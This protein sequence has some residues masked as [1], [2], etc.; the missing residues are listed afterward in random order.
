MNDIRFAVRL[1]RKNSG[2]TIAAVAVLALGIGA[3]TAIFSLVNAVLLKPLPYREPERLTMLWGNVQRAVVERRGNSFPD[4]FDW[5]ERSRSFEAMSAVWDAVWI[6]PGAPDSERIQGEIVSASYFPLLGVN[7]RMGRL[8]RPEEDHKQDAAPPVVVIG[9]GLWKRRFGADPGILG[10]SIQVATGFRPADGY[11]R[12][13]TVVGVMPDGFRGLSDEAEMWMPVMAAGLGPVLE[14]RGTRGFPALAR[15]RPG[16]NREMAQRDLDAIST[17]LQKEYPGTNRQRGV[18]VALLS[19]EVTGELRPALLVILGAAGFVMLLACAN[20]GNLMLSRAEARHKELAVRAALGAGKVRLLRQLSIEAMVL[21]AMGA[22]AGLLIA[23][24]GTEALMTA[25]PVRFLSW[26]RPEIDLGVIGFTMLISLVTA[27]VL[28]L[29]PAL[30][31]SEPALQE[32]LQESSGRTSSR[33]RLRGFLVASE[34]A[35]ALVL[36]AGA[37]L[38]IRSFHALSRLDPG[39]RTDGVLT[40]RVSLPPRAQDHPGF[41]A[42][43]IREK[44]RN[45]PGVEEASLSTDLPL[46]GGGSAIFFTAEGQPVSDA[47]TMPRAHNHRVTPGFFRALG[48]RVRTGRDF[49][50]ADLQAPEISVVIVSEGIA[51]RF[52][53]GQDPIGKRIKGGA[54]A[55]KS[56]WMEIIGVV[57]ETKY[58]SLPRNPTPD[59]DIFLPFSEQAQAFAVL[60]RAGVD[61]ASLT[62]PARDAVRAVNAGAV[63]HTVQT[64]AERAGRQTARSRFTTWLMGIFTA[65][66]LLLAAVGIYAV[67]AQS[68]SR[69]TREIGIRMA[70][71]AAQGDVLRMVVLEG[72]RLTAAGAAA[73]LAAA[74]I[75]TR[76]IKTQLFGVGETD[77]LAFTAAPVVLLAIAAVATWLPAR[78]AAKVDPMEALRYE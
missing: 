51:K 10:R 64:L 67:I 33:G 18:E 44:L 32:V 16:V 30:A 52:W 8:F 76:L 75:L 62:K 27:G 58:R 36:L 68:V 1:L 7:P 34:V 39:F 31:A 55:S 41:D 56:P 61:P 19:N 29:A 24:W 77:P 42:R 11:T 3:N 45:L 38:F 40:F 49:T 17:Q 12:P 15:L 4:F 9:A 25:S 37:G 2:F 65:A 35:L 66:A 26:V 71:G 74:L 50:T 23:L 63:V 28:G 59:P 6:L 20:V 22:A 72:L 21:T 13:Y 43:E 46:S 48:I 57:E 5:R 47:Q 14:E 69:R 73:G 54:P 60:L 70:L 78:R 53:P